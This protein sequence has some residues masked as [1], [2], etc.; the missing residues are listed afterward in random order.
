M[1]EVHVNGED[2][3]IPVSKD[4]DEPYKKPTKVSISEDD[5]NKDIP[6][7]NGDDHNTSTSSEECL[8]LSTNTEDVVTNGHS[9]LNGH[10][11]A[12]D[13][14]IPLH[15]TTSLHQLKTTDNVTLAAN[16]NNGSPI[17]VSEELNVSSSET[18]LITNVVLN[19]CDEVPSNSVSSNHLE[20]SD[21]SMPKEAESSMKDSFI[22]S[23]DDVPLTESYVKISTPES[24]SEIS[25]ASAVETVSSEVEPK[26]EVDA[27]PTSVETVNSPVSETIAA[28]VL[29]STVETVPSV[30]ETESAQALA[31]TTAVTPVV[32]ETAPVTPVVAETAPVDAEPAPVTPVVAEPAPVTPVVAEPAPVT[33]VAAETAPVVA[34]TAPVTPVVAE[35]ALVVAEPAPVTPAV[36]ET[37]PVAAEPAQV[38]AEP[39]PV[40]PVVAET[41]PVVAETAPVTPVVAETAPVA[42]EPAPVVAE[43]APLTPA[44]PEPAPVTETLPVESEPAKPV[45]EWLDILGN[46]LLKKKVSY[47]KIF[48]L[49]SKI[50]FNHEE[51]LMHSFIPYFYVG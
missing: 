23:V 10:A 42:G 34:E 37:T 30:Q 4:F 7:T 14:D 6:T 41:A 12:A 13:S 2:Y 17:I 1:A 3:T 51:V 38:V 25:S 24:E 46:G 16:F 44:I 33:P 26:P 29:E 50:I 15:A 39:A 47:I 20:E 35:P 43:T 11:A 28:P 8:D 45:N 49:T 21:E 5:V 31:E 32:A 19:A 18:E 22:K 9:E 36:A 27:E 48:I 40:T